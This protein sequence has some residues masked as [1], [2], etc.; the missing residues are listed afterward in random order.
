[1]DT[2]GAITFY[3]VFI[4]NAKKTEGKWYFSSSPSSSYWRMGPELTRLAGDWR[5]NISGISWGS[6]G[7]KFARIGDSPSLLLIDSF[8]IEYWL[9]FGSLWVSSCAQIQGRISQNLKLPIYQSYQFSAQ[10]ST[11]QNNWG[12]IYVRSVEIVWRGMITPG[13]KSLPSNKM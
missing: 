13:G 9:I 5:A 11:I 1:M 8:K 6:A 2:M 7:R 3:V 12:N 4:A 10:E